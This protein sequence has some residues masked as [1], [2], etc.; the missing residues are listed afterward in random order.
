M[1]K[2]PRPKVSRLRPLG[3]SALGRGVRESEGVK[4][5]EDAATPSNKEEIRRGGATRE[6]FH[7]QIDQNPAS[8]PKDEDFRRRSRIRNMFEDD[9]VD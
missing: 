2:A 8:R 9:G 3:G 7:D 4:P 1:A 6:D 5:E